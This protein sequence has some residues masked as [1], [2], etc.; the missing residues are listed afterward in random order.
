MLQIDITAKCC[1]RIG[2]EQPCKAAAKLLL[3]SYRYE[4]FYAL[5]PKRVKLMYVLL[6]YR[7][8]QA[9]KMPARWNKQ[10][11]DNVHIKYYQM[12]GNVMQSMN[13]LDNCKSR[14]AFH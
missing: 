14:F 4:K 10:E 3:T 13:T 11:K 1:F 12:S 5:T 9:I 2:Y 7:T 6:F 8:T